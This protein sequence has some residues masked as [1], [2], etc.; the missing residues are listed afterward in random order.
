MILGL[1]IG[2]ILGMYIWFQG[3]IWLLMVSIIIIIFALIGSLVDSFI[4]KENKNTF[5]E[6]FGAII[7]KKL[8]NGKLVPIKGK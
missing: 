1:I 4:F 3:E 8:V 7:N 2:S 5:K 6:F